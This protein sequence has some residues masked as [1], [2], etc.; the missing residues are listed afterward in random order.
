M[1]A[2]TSPSPR[3]GPTSE[4]D[5]ASLPQGNCRYIM[6]V[7]E[8]KGCRC[9]C[10]N[11]IL[12]KSLPGSTCEC[13]HLACFHHRTAETPTDKQE[14]DL[15][16]Q[17]VRHLEDLLLKGTDK[18]K[19]IVQRVSQLEEVVDTRTEEI[20]QEIEKTYGNLNRA[21]HSI[22][23]LE[24]RGGEHE[25]RFQDMGGYLKTVD[26]ELHRLDNRQCEL[27]DADLHLEERFIELRETIEHNTQGSPVQERDFS[28][29]A[30]QRQR[31]VDSVF[32]DAVPRVADANVGVN[33]HH[34]THSTD[35]N[36]APS[37]DG[38]LTTS[39]ASEVWTVHISLLPTRS[40][41][42]PFERHTTA[43]K[44]CLSRG[45][46]QM[47]AVNGTSSAAFVSAVTEAF[48]SVLKKRTWVPLQA[49]L[50]DAERLQGLPML[51]PLDAA[52][53]DSEYD[54][55]FLRAHCAVLDRHGKID[56]LY[57]AMRH[58]TISWH[59]LRHSPV[60]L[61]G[62][63]AS[64]N[65]DAILDANESFQEGVSV[66]EDNRPSAGDLVRALPN[67]KR[68]ASEMSKPANFGTCTVTGEEMERPAKA[69]RTACP[70]P[71]LHE[72]R[73]QRVRT[74]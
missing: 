66:D 8:I 14:L 22:G 15:L 35:P 41:P 31:V 19:E 53:V 72:I 46:H 10:V 51:R 25:R 13:G 11:F 20:G 55:D 59:A 60:F 74:A 32:D 33:P 36:S 73:R 2:N 67:L 64:W 21:W 27:N 44:R 16:H 24:R 63:E 54:V 65:Y 62:L 52:L 50:C 34:M 57:I 42:F 26:D 3:M 17:R 18:E 56:S 23:E 9:A 45:L 40:Q 48:G 47:V 58:S 5:D 6:L 37:Q 7:P 43:Y 4:T 1:S 69:S 61:P 68:G 70:M 39:A 38:A 28:R 30:T 29:S 49:K 12:N 71:N